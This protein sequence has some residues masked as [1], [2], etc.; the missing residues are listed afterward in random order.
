MATPAQKLVKSGSA[1]G[2]GL[3]FFTLTV[4][5]VDLTANQPALNII[6]ETVSTLAQPVIVDVESATSLKFAVEHVAAID[7]T[8]MGALIQAAVRAGTALS[9]MTATLVK[10][11][12]L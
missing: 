2:S 3:E 11:D 12:L 5:N 1:L 9:T 7:A 4:A 8:A 6:I 10:A